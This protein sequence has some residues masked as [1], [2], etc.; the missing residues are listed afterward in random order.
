MNAQTQHLS[1]D[2][3]VAILKRNVADLEVALRTQTERAEAAEV[4]K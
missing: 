1:T 3:T 4:P 2:D